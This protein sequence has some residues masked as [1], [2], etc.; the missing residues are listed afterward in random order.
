VETG[1]KGSSGGI[2]C[3]VTAS[4]FLGTM[5]SLAAGGCSVARG[6]ILTALPDAEARAALR[7]STIVFSKRNDLYLARGDG[8]GAA[9]LLSGLE[10]GPGGAIFIPALTLDGRRLAFLSVVGLEARESVGRELSLH[11]ITLSGERPGEA[12]VAAWDQV[13]LDRIALPDAAGS[14]SVFTAAA[15]GWAADGGRIALGLNRPAAAGGD[16][17]LILT[18][19]GRPTVLYALGSRELPPVG[20]IS[21]LPDGSGLILGLESPDAETGLAARL[22]FPNGPDGSSSTGEAATLEIVGTGSYP[23]LSHEGTRIAVIA[24]SGGAADLVM[25]SPDGQE[26]DRFARPAGRAPTRP[27]WSPDGR[28]LYYYSL[29]ST[30]PLGLLDVTVLRCLDT[31]TRRIFDVASL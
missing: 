31:R 6:P 30:G 24:A 17:V 4:L 7:R 23:A 16:A 11:I 13:R 2:V 15:A 3:I 19:E 29:A 22:L 18:S 5:M 21:W 9:R 12:R 8:S 25:L 20:S 14:H 1:S 28:Y 10:I 27:F 26:I